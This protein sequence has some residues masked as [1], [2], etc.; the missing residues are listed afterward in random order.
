M[1][2]NDNR[3]VIYIGFIIPK[4]MAIKNLN[5]FA[6]NEAETN[7]VANVLKDYSTY[8]CSYLYNLFDEPKKVYISQKKIEL[9]GCGYKEAVAISV[10]KLPFIR[11]I[12]SL[13]SLKNYL[14][15]TIGKILAENPDAD[16]TII[17]CNSY[18]LFSIPA[19]QIAKKLNIRT[20]AYQIDGFYYEKKKNLVRFFNESLAKK[21]LK[22]YDKVISLSERVL[23]DFCALN[24][25]QM[26]ITPIAY[27]EKD[28]QFDV[29]QYFTKDSFNIVFAGGIAPLNGIR[30]YC[31]MSEK[32]RK[33]Y[34]IHLFGTGEIREELE[35]FVKDKKNIVYHGPVPHDELMQIEK[36]ADTLIIIRPTENNAQNSITKYGIPFKLIE[37]LK[38]GIPVIAS[39][40]DALPKAFHEYINFCDANVDAVLDLVYTI[41][42]SK[43][44]YSEKAIRAQTYMKEN[45][46]WDVYK[47]QIEEFIYYE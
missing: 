9:P 31:D 38:S 37:Y 43:K 22:Q 32:I 12:G 29:S 2:V 8:V 44:E 20:V 42:E 25:T 14:K 47:K 21:K 39:H 18:P 16:I 34:Q 27:E 5:S 45:C 13:I 1:A 7:F 19:L 36:R 46:I 4:T 35:S 15:R 11:R 26:A 24:Q 30:F 23:S 10:C 40:M 6:G 41:N 33:G 17:T 3:Y 28:P